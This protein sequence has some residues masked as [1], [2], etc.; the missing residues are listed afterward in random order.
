MFSGSVENGKRLKQIYN[1]DI[2]FVYY[3]YICY[4]SKFD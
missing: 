4:L 1:H 3:S 2:E